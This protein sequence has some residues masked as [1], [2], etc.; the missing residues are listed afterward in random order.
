MYAWYVQAI[1]QATLKGIGGISGAG[2]WKEYILTYRTNPDHEIVT[3]VP[4]QSEC[5]A[6]KKLEVIGEIQL[7]LERVT[8][9]EPM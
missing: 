4:G 5:K 2:P 6:P 7:I 1:R 3:C 8:G 9:V